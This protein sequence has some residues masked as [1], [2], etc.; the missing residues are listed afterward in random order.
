MNKHCVKPKSAPSFEAGLIA[1][2][3]ARWQLFRFLLTGVLNTAVGLIIFALA[4]AVQKEID[5]AILAV[6]IF[7]VFFNFITI[8]GYAFKLLLVKRFPAFF[9]TYVSIFFLN[10]YGQDYLEQFLV[11]PI[12]RQIILAPPLAIISFL[13]LKYL[14]FFKQKTKRSI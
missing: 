13:L 14:V 2:N 8:G 3:A 5:V 12:I 4:L 7:G 11:Y 1:E 6:S 10:K 9:F